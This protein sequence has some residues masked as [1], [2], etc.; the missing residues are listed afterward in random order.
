MDAGQYI[1]TQN[2]TRQKSYFSDQGYLIKKEDRFG[3]T[4]LYEYGDTDHPTLISKI[5]DELGR[6]ISFTYNTSGKVT[7]VTGKTGEADSG[8]LLLI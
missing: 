3:N 7:T 8:S 1:I 5:T 6:S 4:L 2:L